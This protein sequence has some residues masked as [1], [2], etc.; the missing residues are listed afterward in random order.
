MMVGGPAIHAGFD[1]LG[2][3]GTDAAVVELQL[4]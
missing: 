4:A 2:E 3:A 1:E